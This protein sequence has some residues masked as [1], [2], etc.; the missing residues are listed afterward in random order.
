[1]LSN[2][3]PTKSAVPFLTASVFLGASG[4][5]KRS[6]EDNEADT[7][8]PR[9]KR[10]R[11]APNAVAMTHQPSAQVSTFTPPAHIAAL[12]CSWSPTK[13]DLARLFDVLSDSWWVGKVRSEFTRGGSLM[14]DVPTND[15]GL[16]RAH[17]HAWV[18]NGWWN[19]RLTSEDGRYVA[20][21]VAPGGCRGGFAFAHLP[22]G[23]APRSVVPAALDSRPISVL[24][25]ETCEGMTATFSNGVS[26]TSDLPD[27]CLSLVPWL[28]DFMAEATNS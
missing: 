24:L 22:A 23:S 21:A 20:F 25:L 8:V 7:Y 16:V 18:E 11:S 19:I 5:M 1:M 14:L 3:V 4:Q 10:A 28:S 13:P 12:S 26:T 27:G 17:G 15:G 6:A 9:A 2:I